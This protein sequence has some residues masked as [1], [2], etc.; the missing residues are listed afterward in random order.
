MR[1]DKEDE[2]KKSRNTRRYFENFFLK[3]DEVAAH[4]SFFVVELCFGIGSK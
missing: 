3:S 1:R 2:R 4:G